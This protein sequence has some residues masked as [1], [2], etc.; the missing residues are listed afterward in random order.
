MPMLNML[1]IQSGMEVVMEQ[2]FGNVLL[3][4]DFDVA[5]GV[6]RNH[7]VNA[8]TI[9]GDLVKPECKNVNFRK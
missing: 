6:T 9:G 8:V 7:N 1:Q 4:S 2:V 3:C 5:I